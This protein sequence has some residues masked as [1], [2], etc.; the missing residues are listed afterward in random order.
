MLHMSIA[1]GNV[2]SLLD[3][4]KVYLNGELFRSL[5]DCVTAIQTELN[6]KSGQYVPVSLSTLGKNGALLGGIALALQHFFQV[7]QLQLHFDD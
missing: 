3:P 1:I 4:E 7:P 2:V 5:P 6:R